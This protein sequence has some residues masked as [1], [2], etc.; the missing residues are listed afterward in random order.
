MWRSCRTIAALSAALVVGGAAAAEAPRRYT[1]LDAQELGS[2]RAAAE[3]RAGVAAASTRVPTSGP[4]SEVLLVERRDESKE[5]YEGGDWKRRADVYIYDYSSDTLRHSIVDVETGEVDSEEL[6][7][8]V[9]LP[10][11]DG[12]VQRALGIAYGDP[13]TRQAIE[14]RYR[15]I[16]GELLGGTDQLQVKAFVFLSDSKPEGLNEDARGCGLRR[17]AQLLLYTKDR[18]VI[19]VQPIVDLSNGRVAQLLDF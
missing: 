19:E 6:V 10:L 3:A 4:A 2:A 9:Q 13:A 16:S 17:C 18:V 14:T 8:G 7:Q 12:E 11:T 15:E 5:V 1:P